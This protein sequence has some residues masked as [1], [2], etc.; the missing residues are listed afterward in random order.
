MGAVLSVLLH[1][2]PARPFCI[3]GSVCA[4]LLKDE[5]MQGRL[6]CFLDFFFSQFMP[7][8]KGRGKNYR[9]CLVTVGT[10]R[11]RLRTCAG[12]A[13]G[14]LVGAH[15]AGRTCAAGAYSWDAALLKEGLQKRVVMQ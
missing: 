13:G 14:V 9:Y 3:F 10:S 5:R 2:R 4:H 1:G 7:I 8:E 6:P 15:G 12:H 11:P